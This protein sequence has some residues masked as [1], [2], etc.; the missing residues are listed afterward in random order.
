MVEGEDPAATKKEARRHRA[1]EA[2]TADLVETIFAQYRDRHLATLRP[3]TRREIARLFEKRVLPT[4]GKRRISEI[5]KRDVIAALDEMVASGAPVSANRLLAY[6][7]AFFNW[8][9]SRDVLTVSPCAGIKRPTTQKARDRA[10]TDDEVRWLW[11]ACDAIGWPFG[12]M[13]RL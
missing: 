3:S 12:S 13:T 4:W 1:A 11:Q 6:L 9:I 8:A 7:T 5:S 10:L 2:D